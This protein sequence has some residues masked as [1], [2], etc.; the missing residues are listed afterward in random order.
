[1]PDPF[2][3]KPYQQNNTWL[4]QQMNHL[5][6]IAQ[7]QMRGIPYPQTATGAGLGF[8]QQTDNQLMNL[9]LNQYAAQGALGGGLVG[10]GLVG[11]TPVA[12]WRQ[13][14]GVAERRALKLFRDMYG[15]RALAKYLVRG[16]TEL[17]VDKRVYRVFRERHREIEVFQATSKGRKML[18]RLCIVDT[19]NVPLTDGVMKR[20]WLI[21]A[22]RDALYTQANI[23]PANV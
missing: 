9:I 4:L 3:G 14:W 7:Q 21:R 18:Y 5:D 11:G 17:C 20:L 13:R 15:K 8:N 2:T 1:M 22:D 19:D 12:S 23:K 16:Y 6:Q 10:G